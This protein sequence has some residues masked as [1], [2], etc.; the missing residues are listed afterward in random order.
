M[1]GWFK[2]SVF[3]QNLTYLAIQRY[4]VYLLYSSPLILNTTKRY[5]NGIQPGSWTS[6]EQHVLRTSRQLVTLLHTK[7]NSIFELSHVDIELP[8]S[9]PKIPKNVDNFSAKHGLRVR[10]VET[11]LITHAL[12]KDGLYIRSEECVAAV[13]YTHLTLPTTP[14]V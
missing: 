4:M 14:Y 5:Y 11:E 6:F 13:S 8:Y 2:E 10:D 12:C 3:N 9:G 1:Q 7:C